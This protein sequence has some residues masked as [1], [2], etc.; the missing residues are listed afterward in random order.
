MDYLLFPVARS[1]QKS[2]INAITFLFTVIQF[3]NVCFVFYHW[4]KMV[5]HGHF[6]IPWSDR[7]C[8]IS[9]IIQL[10]TV[11]PF[12]DALPYIFLN[13]L[14][15]LNSGDIT[16]FIVPFID[17][18]STP[19]SIEIL[20]NAVTSEVTPYCRVVGRLPILQTCLL[21]CHSGVPLKYPL[22]R[23]IVI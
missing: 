6:P 21:L 7:I 15:T 23:S 5:D 8:V 3:V 2:V 22:S 20:I 4:F 1:D 12:V 10:F 17:A 16:D 19:P 9:L 18:L 11:V 13:S 14:N